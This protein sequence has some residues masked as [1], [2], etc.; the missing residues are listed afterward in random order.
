[1]AN[2]QPVMPGGTQ[3]NP[4]VAD[5][6]GA[7]AGGN[8]AGVAAV[9]GQAQKQQASDAPMSYD[10]DITVTASRHIGEDLGRISQSQRQEIYALSDAGVDGA[11]RHAVMEDM[12]YGGNGATSGPA[13]D[14]SL[15]HAAGWDQ[16]AIPLAAYDNP[17]AFAFTNPPKPS[18][19]W[20]RQ[21]PGF[22][23]SQISP[24][25][26]KS[27]LVPMRAG[28]L[29]L[30]LL[31]T[32]GFTR[33]ARG[34]VGLYSAGSEILATE[35]KLA[36]GTFDLGVSGSQYTLRAPTIAGFEGATGTVDTRAFVVHGNS[37]LSPRPAT[38]YEL[39][40]VGEDGSLT[41]LKH[42]ISQNPATRYSKS[43]MED[44]R[45]F[46]V[47]TGPRADMLALERQRVTQNPGPLNFEPWAVN[48]RSG[49]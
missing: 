34:A 48:A 49:Q 37:K 7:V 19:F 25:N 27:E 3:N 29:G 24:V 21:V 5:N 39:Y 23:T 11:L 40:Q 8:S 15:V 38:L 33:S 41:F 26:G 44:K 47:A 36:G 20:S 14:A 6:L 1:M 10:M 12:L 17:P 2:A 16:S 42:G 45:F 43:F 32:V 46:E 13:F 22:Y 30:E 4:T 35:T 18:D 31:G 28:E 9:I